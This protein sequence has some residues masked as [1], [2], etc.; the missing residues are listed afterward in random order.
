MGKEVL[1][2]SPKGALTQDP[3]GNDSGKNGGCENN[4]PAESPSI[5]VSFPKGFAGSVFI[6]GDGERQCGKISYRR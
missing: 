5:F 6:H 1:G 2:D 3:L 4:Y